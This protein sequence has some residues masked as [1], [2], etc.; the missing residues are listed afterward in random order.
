MSDD[1]DHG[2]SGQGRPALPH[3]GSGTEP[4]SPGL[5]GLSGLGGLGGLLESAQE[6]LSAQ[7]RAAD[8]VVE[9]TAGGGVVRVEMS[10]A[11]EVRS[12]TIAPEVVDPDEVEMLQD[13]VVA[14]LHDAAAKVTALQREALGAFGGLDLGSLGDV[15]DIGDIGGPPFPGQG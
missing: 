4:G 14:A 11:G 13:L 8:E 15:G 12:V 1:S 3:T 2:F 10:G 6:A 9:G 7:A 5:A